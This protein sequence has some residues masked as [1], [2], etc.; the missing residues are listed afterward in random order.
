MMPYRTEA[1]SWSWFVGMMRRRLLLAK[2]R[3][4]LGRQKK[5]AKEGGSRSAILRL[6][7]QR[8]LLYAPTYLHAAR[9]A[10]AMTPIRALAS[11]TTPLSIH[12]SPALHDQP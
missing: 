4:F 9:I 8:T 3:L 12:L 2:E 10:A 7:A 11:S 1:G 6:H 5:A